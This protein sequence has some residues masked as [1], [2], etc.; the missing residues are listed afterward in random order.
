LEQVEKGLQT[1]ESIC[2]SLSNIY[3]EVSNKENDTL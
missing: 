1:I 2:D 3:N